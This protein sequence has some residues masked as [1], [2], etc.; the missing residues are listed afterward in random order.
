[1]H[2]VLSLTKLVYFFVC[3]LR[4]ATTACTHEWSWSERVGGR[5]KERMCVCVCVGIIKLKTYIMQRY[6]Q[7][8]FIS[9][10]CVVCGMVTVLNYKR[11]KVLK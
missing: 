5:V 7:K 1:M 6:Y 9:L 10:S 8:I 4:I 11:L 3:V 2:H